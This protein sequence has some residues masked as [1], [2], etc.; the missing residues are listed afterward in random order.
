M[1]CLC[2]VSSAV[3]GAGL[4]VARA[5]AAEPGPVRLRVQVVDVLAHARDAFPVVPQRRPAVLL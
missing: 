3:S 2:A 4:G 1:A 5:A